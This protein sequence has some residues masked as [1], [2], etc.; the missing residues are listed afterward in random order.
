MFA[1]P[2]AD[3]KAAG[4]KGG[5]WVYVTHE[6]SDIQALLQRV[7]ERMVTGRLTDDVRSLTA[8]Q[9]AAPPVCHAKGELSNKRVSLHRSRSTWS[10]VSL[11][12]L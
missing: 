1:E 9:E 12:G 11:Q 3:T 2:T 10:Q 7:K 6:L 8:C 4:M 5:E